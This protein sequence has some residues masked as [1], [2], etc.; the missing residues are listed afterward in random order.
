[1]DKKPK[2]IPLTEEVKASLEDPY[3]KKLVI[4]KAKKY[5]W[6]LPIGIQEEDLIS[7]GYEGLVNAGQTFDKKK[8]TKLESWAEKQIDWSILNYLQ[9]VDPL[10]K[11]ARKDLKI[12]NQTREELHDQLGRYPDHT[13]IAKYL[14]WK[15]V[16]VDRLLWSAQVSK[17]RVR[18]MDSEPDEADTEPAV[19]IQD[20]SISC[21]T[22]KITTDQNIE[23]V[24]SMLEGIGEKA[25]VVLQMLRKGL[26]NKEVAKKLGVPENNVNNLRNSGISQIKKKLGLK[27]KKNKVG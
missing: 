26:T 6:M 3:F 11:E 4:A 22:E 19:V 7:A 17:N 2:D 21:P 25:K 9:Q 20:H 13:E 15:D 12:I 16:K 8:H 14:G 1:M 27:D 5:R 24:E 23:L 10:S 18:S